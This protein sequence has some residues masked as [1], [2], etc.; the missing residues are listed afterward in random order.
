MSITSNDVRN[1]L[2]DMSAEVDLEMLQEFGEQV[3][4]SNRGGAAVTLYCLPERDGQARSRIWANT[5]SKELPRTFRIP[6]QDNF[7]PTDGPA[8][9]D[10]FTDVDGLVYVVREFTFNDL[11]SV[12]TFK[13]CINT[14]GQQVGE[15]G[16]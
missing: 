1:E 13:D 11:G 10:T 6:K 2:R 4:Y 9:D 15:V 14:Q 7:P 3:L 12:C 8:I 5:R 16:Q